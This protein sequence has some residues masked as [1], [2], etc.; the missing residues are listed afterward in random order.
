MGLAKAASSRTRMHHADLCCTIGRHATFDDQATLSPSQAGTQ[1]PVTALV[2]PVFWLHRR[3]ILG[4]ETLTLTRAPFRS[5]RAKARS[6]AASS[7]M[8][9]DFLPTETRRSS[10]PSRSNVMWSFVPPPW[11]ILKRGMISA[12][13]DR[14]FATD[15]TYRS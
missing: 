12:D 13:F 14:F 8:I 3:Q 2:F 10:S 11:R 6:L 4:A 5:R 1:A 7:S 15:L 9:T